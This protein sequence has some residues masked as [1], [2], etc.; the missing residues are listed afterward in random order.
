MIPAI[1]PN[2]IQPITLIMIHLST[3]DSGVE[4]TLTAVPSAGYGRSLLADAV[5]IA[6]NVL[7]TWSAGGRLRRPAIRALIERTGRYLLTPGRVHHL[8]AF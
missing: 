1:N 4:L 2:K 6:S 8:H 7:G 5:P 3:R